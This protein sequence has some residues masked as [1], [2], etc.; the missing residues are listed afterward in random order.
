[1][2]LTLADIERRYTRYLETTGKAHGTKANYRQLFVN[3]HRFSKDQDLTVSTKTLTIDV[4]REYQYWLITTP[5][6]RP[7]LGSTKRSPGGVFLQMELIKRLCDWLHEEGQLEQPI[8]VKLPKVP[9]RRRKVLT[10]QELNRLLASPYLD[11]T[12][13]QG[14]RNLALFTLMLDCGLRLAEVAP[15]TDDSFYFDS[16]MLRVVGK[17]D[18]ERFVPFSRQTE[19]LL[20]DWIAERT[21]HPINPPSLE[22]RGKTFN[23]SRGGICELFRK[24]RVEADVPGLSPHVMRH[25]A[26]TSMIANGME[27]FTLKRILGHSDIKTTEIYVHQDDRDVKSKHAAASPVA[28]FRGSSEPSLPSRQAKIA[29]TR[30]KK[31]HRPG[32]VVSFN[33][34]KVS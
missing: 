16:G 15:L 33:T 4:V 13:P 26:A 10:S 14:L 3:L 12:H 30:A 28:N 20:L 6:I 9:F 5:L 11:A 7:S 1:M 24:I 31:I 23:L 22:A 27:P 25:T 8:A 17:G 34:R 18:K 19:E 32:N 29:R 2:E 21:A